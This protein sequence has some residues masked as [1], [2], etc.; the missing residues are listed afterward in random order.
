ME[1]SDV[2]SAAQTAELPRSD[3]YVARQPIFDM[4]SEIYGYELLYRSNLDNWYQAGDAE[5]ASLS[6]L[7][8]SAFVFGVE[9]MAGKGKAFVNFTRTA[10]IKD[11][12][13]VLPAQKLV[14][15]VLEGIQADDE[16]RAACMR[17]KSDGY[18]LALDDWDPH[19]PTGSL[20]DLADIIKIDFMMFD[21]ERRK[22]LG[23]Q[24]T[25]RG[26]AL[27]AEKVET[28]EDAQQARDFGYEYVQGYFYA[29][30]EIKVGARS[31]GFK[32][33]R[34]QLLGVL[35]GSDPDLDRIEDLLRHDPA[36]S[37]QI[38]SYLNSASFGLRSRVTSIRQA[39]F[40]LGQAGIRTWATVVI[41]ADAGSDRPNELIVT[42]V[43]RGRFCELVGRAVGL[44]ARQHDLS[45]LGLFSMID[46]IVGRELE[47]T[48]EAVCLPADVAAA[49]RGEPGIFSD[50]LNLAR[51]YERADWPSVLQLVERVGL[52]ISDV[53]SIYLDAVEWGNRTHLL[54]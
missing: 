37:F 30:P 5:L 52:P 31:S 12:A 29:R 43:A 8:N 49:I 46:A 54:A 26:I 48:L 34:L 44:E 18:L 10:L 23:E 15:E 25:R 50:L 7:S 13:R 20:V 45:L 6:V 35:N 19:G 17:L 4:R 22:Q 2:A 14:V 32:P 11:Y 39:I 28:A 40:M 16:V 47:P 33:H 41:L 36:L 51:A 53:P 21:E 38:I 42:S 9:A 27:L 1:A 3:V 24:L